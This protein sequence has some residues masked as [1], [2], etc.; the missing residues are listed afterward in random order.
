MAKTETKAT[1][2]AEKLPEPG[3]E[4]KV[5]QPP[6]PTPP[7]LAEPTVPK[8]QHTELQE[9][10]NKALERIKALEGEQGRVQKLEDG[11]TALRT[12]LEIQQAELTAATIV[13]YGEEGNAQA[14]D[15]LAEREMNRQLAS[16]GLTWD[17]PRLVNV[18]PIRD[19][20]KAGAYPHLISILPALSLNQPAPP[21]TPPPVEN[22]A[23]PPVGEAEKI[24]G[25]TLEELKTDWAKESGL[26]NPATPPPAGIGADVNTLGGEEVLRLAVQQKADEGK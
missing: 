4:P 20:S 2:V 23:E 12:G 1:P 16:R 25:K 10:H 24:G 13:K 11:F 6:T 14:A 3:Q 15:E 21:E 7:S 18:R 8:S 22:P 26:L 19:V 5:A 9:A 17:D